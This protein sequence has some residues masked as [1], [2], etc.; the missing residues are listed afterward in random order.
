MINS[1]ID[2]IKN[3]NTLWRKFQKVFAEKEVPSKTILLNEGDIASNVFFIKKGCIRLWFN[4]D[5]RDITFQFFME[6]QT[7][8]SMDSFLNN[9]PSIFSIESIEPSIIQIIKKK[10]FEEFLY[11]SPKLKDLLYQ[12]VLKRFS[13]YS[14]LFLSHIK[15]TPQERYEELLDNHPEIIRRIPQHYIASYL[16]ITSVSLSRIRNRK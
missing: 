5:G 9:E 11:N 1:L 4:K 13:N 6:N 12:H 7:I 16:G 8:A 15:N 2:E 14:Q 10:D 3:D